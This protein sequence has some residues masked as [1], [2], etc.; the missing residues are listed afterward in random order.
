MNIIIGR[1]DQGRVKPSSV[2]DYYHSDAQQLDG[3]DQLAAPTTGSAPDDAVVGEE[4]INCSSPRG[5]L[6]P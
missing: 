3:V 1:P 4:E 2:L 6:D 5:Q